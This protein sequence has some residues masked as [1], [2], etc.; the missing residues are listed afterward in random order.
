MSSRP[1]LTILAVLAL[2]GCATG[3]DSA[4]A[5]GLAG[6]TLRMTATNGQVTTLRFAEDGS[7]RARFGG[8]SLDGRWRV[9][10]GRLCFEWPRAR[11]ECWPYEEPFRRGRTRTIT[12]DRGNVVQVTA[13]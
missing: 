10:R 11:R 1:L 9:S 2:A 8:R 13:I 6:Q 5:G 3:R 7:V 4:P 12:S